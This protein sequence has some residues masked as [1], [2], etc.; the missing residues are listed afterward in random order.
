MI[1]FKTSWT[2]GKNLQAMVR[3]DVGGFG[4]VTANTWDCDLE[5]AIAWEAGHNTYLDLGYRARGQWQDLGANG[6]G[7]LGG[8]F[9]GPE[10]G[11]TWRW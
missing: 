11:V 10:I 4:V 2:L 3:G 8:W 5:A 6:G 9:F 7:S 1:G